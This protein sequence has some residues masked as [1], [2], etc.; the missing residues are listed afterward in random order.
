[1]TW[2]DAAARRRRNARQREAAGRRRACRTTRA[3]LVRVSCVSCAGRNEAAVRWAVPS[4]RARRCRPMVPVMLTTR[5]VRR[6]VRSRGRR[7]MQRMQRKDDASRKHL[8][9]TQ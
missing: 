1:M 9:K 3:R 2:R 4:A 8:T 6:R 7:A 5:R